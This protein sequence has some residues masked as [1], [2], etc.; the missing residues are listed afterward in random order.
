MGGRRWEAP[1]AAPNGMVHLPRL[2]VRGTWHAA[3]RMGEV[4]GPYVAAALLPAAIIAALF[5]FDH[6]VSSQMAQQEVRRRHFV[7]LER[8]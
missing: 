3:Q 2:Q 5:W 4:P 8:T 6:G 1:W 7:G